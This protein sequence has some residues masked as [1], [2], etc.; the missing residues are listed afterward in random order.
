VTCKTLVV[1]PHPFRKTHQ[2]Q[3]GPFLFHANGSN[4]MGVRKD[5][6]H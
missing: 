2:R 4:F 6:L 5:E 1:A 3:G